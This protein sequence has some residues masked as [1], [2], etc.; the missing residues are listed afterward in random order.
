MK[1]PIFLILLALTVFTLFVFL[2][3]HQLL[4]K[5]LSNK[6]KQAKITAKSF[7]GPMQY[8]MASE[9]ANTSKGIATK[10][11]ITFDLSKDKTGI[12]QISIAIGEIKYEIK[13]PDGTK[14]GTRAGTNIF[15][16]GPFS[17]SKN[18]FETRDEKDTISVKGTFVSPLKAQGSA[19]L[20]T[21]VTVEF[22]RFDVDL[23]E[24]RWKATGY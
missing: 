19:H 17:I 1:R 22:T 16:N 24:W 6:N 20:Y 4:A 11:S 7:K 15:I 2:C 9:S 14:T 23:G 21:S 10:V 8:L 13:T 5:S 12:T 18:I 3:E